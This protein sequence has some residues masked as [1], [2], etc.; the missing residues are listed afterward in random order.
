MK[1][2]GF[3]SH[4]TV[5][6]LDGQGHR[7]EN[8]EEFHV[9]VLFDLVERVEISFLHAT[10]CNLPQQATSLVSLHRRH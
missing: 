8:I 6:E 1:R 4:R 10:G 7:A 5:V 9:L 3:T 2:G